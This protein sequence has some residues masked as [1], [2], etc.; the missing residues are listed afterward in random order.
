LAK[1]PYIPKPDNLPPLA[2]APNQTINPPFR[3]A[4][5]ILSKEALPGGGINYRLGAFLPG[6]GPV[7]QA[8]PEVIQVS[9]EEIDSHVSY[10]ELERFEHAEFEAQFL[11][12]HSEDE[13]FEHRQIH[14]SRRSLKKGRG[15]P[16]KRKGQDDPFIRSGGGLL[17]NIISNHDQDSPGIESDTS[18]SAGEGIPYDPPLL[19]DRPTITDSLLT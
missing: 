14:K 9:A 16:K 15:R 19:G 2:P 18:S 17:G 5:R 8:F 6:A 10:E 12:D 11:R 7:D 1:P 4:R 3:L 13:E